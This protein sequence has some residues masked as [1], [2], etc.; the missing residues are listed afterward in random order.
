MPQK[1]SGQEYAAQ[2]SNAPERIAQVAMLSP[3]FSTLSYSLPEEFPVDSWRAGQR[4]VLPLGNGVRVGLLLA[5]L[6]KSGAPL[7]T[8]AAGQAITLKPLIWTLDRTPLLPPAYL[9]MLTQLA[10]RLMCHPGRI[11]ASVLPL[12]MRTGKLKLSVFDGGSP[13]LHS[14]SELRQLPKE[15]YRSLAALWAA[16]QGGLVE[17]A[18]GH[19]DQL[20]NEICLLTADP[21]WAVRPA[22]KRQLALLDL[23]WENGPLNRKVIQSKLGNDA[24]QTVKRLIDL[25]L[26]RIRPASA[27][28]EC[29]ETDDLEKLWSDLPQPENH[30]DFELTERQRAVLAALQNALEKEADTHHLLHGITGSGKTVI[31]MELIRR[32]LSLGRSAIL[33]APEVALAIK[34][35]NDL[36][37]SFPNRARQRDIEPEI[38]LAH[39]YQ[40]PGMRERIFRQAASAREPLIIVGTR[41]S[42]FLPLDN[43]GLIILDEEHDSSF[44]QDEGLVY[45]AKEL[46]YS[47]AQEHKALLLLGSATPDVKSFQA[48]RQG[49]LRVHSLPDRVGGGALPSV[50]LVD[51][52]HLGPTDGLLAKTSLEALKETVKRGDQAVILLNRRG[53]APLMHC[54][55]CAQVVKCPCCDIGLT[56][57]KARE[58]LVCHYCG[59]NV[60]FPSPCP[61]C[62]G[63]HFLPFGEGT[64]KL[65]ENLESI[66]PPG[67]GI[68]RLDRDSA[69][70]PGRM[71]E[72]LAAF[73]R[74]EAQVLVGTQMLSKGHHFPDVTLAI[75]A[76]ADLG[77]N[78]P[79]YRATERSF[80]LLV[81]SAGRAGRG[82]KTGRVLIQTR[83]L[84]HYCWDYVRRADF[85]GFFK[86]ELQKRER[87]NYPPF[88]RLALI[89][90]S[91][92]M[93]WKDGREAVD[94]LAAVYREEA[95]RLGVTLLGPA[96]A[97]LAILR[98]RRRFQCLLKAQNWQ[99]IR[100]VFAAG[101]KH[102]VFAGK[103]R[104]ALDLDPMS[105]M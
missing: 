14:L 92:P 20:E 81:Q 56:Y 8:N 67:S 33:L 70:R 45:Q 29:P 73:A 5:V 76:D 6:N 100:L 22:A 19:L 48:G 69:R 7:P 51:I 97:P 104:C 53:Y 101:L 23:L 63:L 40:T 17:R 49:R 60:P 37:K 32:C 27:D 89:R 4:V 95:A 10:S 12:A 94:A 47:L 38:V 46:A 1:S 13:R 28:D 64:E 105:M 18:P 96:P 98:G 50:E 66:L 15:T 11:M 55:R 62:R 102:N 26:L 39:G 80:Q 9:R 79:D 36:R 59:Y 43:V 25:G 84:E 88:S 58:R 71:E 35:R 21:P 78:L 42:L 72:I 65:E 77:L 31:Y 86:V 83:N 61:A 74:G 54:L 16:G 3:P 41:S 34:L 87:L 30:Q 68:L 91:F 75:A 90:L 82:E 24:G 99:S 44:K 85:E 57:H 103:L 52:R 93:D 2:K